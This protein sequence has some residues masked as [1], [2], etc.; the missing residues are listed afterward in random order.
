VEWDEHDY[1]RFFK[2]S[3]ARTDKY[4]ELLDKYG[5]FDEA[6]AKIAKEMGWD[7]CDD[8]NTDDGL[9]IEEINELCEA[10]ANEPP[11]EPDPAREG[12]DWIRTANGDVCH[13]LQHLCS[14]C[15]IKFWRQTEEYGLDQ[16]ADKDL[17]QFFSEFH[18]TGAK[19]AGALNTI[20]CGAGEP[21]AAFTVASLKRA[22]DHLHKAQAGLEA[23]APKRLLP[24]SIITEA[25][26]KLFEIREAILRL[27]NEF[28]G[29]SGA[30]F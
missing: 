6:E 14:E 22:L 23:V 10:A 15:A 21:E 16:F 25:R 18:V 17:E 5:D 27:M 3:D 2:E 9:A 8:G 4:M 1:E 11:P 12:L 29:R 30:Q 19:L 20:A 28:S 13:P 24:E 26:M 7:V